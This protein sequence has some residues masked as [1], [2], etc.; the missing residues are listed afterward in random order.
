MSR[1]W[2]N[3]ANHDVGK[4]VAF[5]KRQRRPYLIT[6]TGSSVAIQNQYFSWLLSDER[7]WPKYLRLLSQVKAEIRRRLPAISRIRVIQGRQY[8]INFAAFRPDSGTEVIDELDLSA[9]Y[10]TAAELLGLMPGELSQKLRRLRK[11]WR[12]RI[13][14]AIATHKTMM[15]LDE[16]GS[17]LRTEIKADAD[18]RR[19]WFAICQLVDRVQRQLSRSLHSDFRF[20]WYDNLFAGAGSLTQ[21]VVESCSGFD[22]R[23]DRG[24]MS[25][26]RTETGLMVRS[27]GRLF[28]LPLIDNHRWRAE[29]IHSWPA[30]QC[31]RLARFRT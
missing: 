15:H 28:C 14:G 22:Y 4:A 7:F 26:K 9:A 3:I 16:T 18:L 19:A 2:Y 21:E 10:L 24:E 1:E 23:I 11:T 29:T 31:N 25:W 27:R 30:G 6:Y 8:L 12:L 20:Y 17:I 13:L 5:F